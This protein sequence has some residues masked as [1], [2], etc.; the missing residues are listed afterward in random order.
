MITIR[1][2]FFFSSSGSA[3]MPSSSGISMSSTTT[4]A[5]LPSI[6]S[7]AS[8]PVR[9]DAPT[10]M[11]G[12][13]STQRATRLRATTESSTTMTR[14][15]LSAATA[16]SAAA[17]AMLMD[18]D[19]ARLTLLGLPTTRRRSPTSDQPDF[20]ELGLDN[21][22]VERLHDVFVGAGVKRTRDVRDVVFGGAEHHLGRVAAGHAAQI[23][24]ELVAVHDRHVPVEQDGV[25]QS[26]L[27]DFQRLLAVLG[28]DDLE[29]QSFQDPSCDL[30]ND[31]GVI[32]DQTCSH[33]SLCFFQIPLRDVSNPNLRR[34]RRSYAA[35]RS[36]TISR[37]RS[38]S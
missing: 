17:K 28:F 23:A 18:S 19:F 2:R 31:A 26:A 21:V 27:A 24:E 25:G 13:P 32:D 7:T 8:R 4:S 29:I 22:L 12:S 6:R 14:I 38:T 33:F 30:S 3:E 9:S 37:T 16:R 11:S 34:C 10:V 1:S 36:G 15:G 5:S 20:L 35:S